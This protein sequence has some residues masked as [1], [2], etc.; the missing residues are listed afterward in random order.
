MRLRVRVRTV[1]GGG[2]V[3]LVRSHAAV[4][5]ALGTSTTHA[6]MTRRRAHARVHTR[7]HGLIRCASSLGC[8]GR[9]HGT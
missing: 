6:D 3:T 1:A 5:C 4:R 8:A 7:C 2:G 9:V